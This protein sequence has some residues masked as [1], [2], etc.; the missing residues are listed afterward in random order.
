MG[1]SKSKKTSQPSLDFKI[2]KR[3]LGKKPPPNPN[4]TVTAFKTRRQSIGE[5]DE[6]VM[7]HR[8]LTL[9]DLLGKMKHYSESVR[10]DALNGLRDLI[11]QHPTILN[12][13]LAAIM[14]GIV[15]LANDH[16]KH[17]RAAVHGVLN[18]LFPHLDSVM[19]TPF[20]PLLTIYVSAGMTHLKTSIRMDALSLFELLVARFPV[21]TAAHCHQ[22]IPNY[23][24]LLKRVTVGTTASFQSSTSSAAS[25]SA[26]P[27][28]TLALN[29]RLQILR[30]L[31]K[32]LQLLVHPPDHTFNRLLQDIASIANNTHNWAP[33]ANVQVDNFEAYSNHK[34]IDGLFASNN[35]VASRSSSRLSTAVVSETVKAAPIEDGVALPPTILATSAEVLLLAKALMPILI[36]C[37]LELSP[38]NPI[39]SYSNL[40]DLELLLQ[41]GHL[42]IH[43]IKNDCHTSPDFKHLR[44]DYAKYFTSHFPLQVGSSSQP[45][46]KEWITSSSINSLMT[47]TMAHFMGPSPKTVPEW[48]G[49][50]LDY[51]EDALDGKLIDEG[52]NGQIVKT[53]IS[54][55]LWIVTLL[56]PSMAQEKSQSILTSFIKFDDNCHPHSAA[57]KSCVFFV[58]ELVD[59]QSTIKD[60]SIKKI[61]EWG[62]SSLPKLLWKLGKSDPSTTMDTTKRAQYDFIQ[63]ALVPFFFTISKPNEKFPN[64]R[65][66]YGP[67]T[68]LPLDI[69]IQALN[70]VYYFTTINMTMVRS[71]IAICRAPKTSF[72]IVDIILD[73]TH[74]KYSVTS[75]NNYLAFC[76]AITLSIAQEKEQ[77]LFVDSD[78]VEIVDSG[79]DVDKKR[80]IH[81][82]DADAQVDTEKEKENQKEKEKAKKS[83]L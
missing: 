72:E 10:K 38:S 49:P 69:Q 7:N 17:V 81:D 26:N 80:K 33:V 73:I 18:M 71:L 53:H 42:L 39:I 63:N 60:K 35:V 36:E 29:T 25:S 32:L 55:L 5:R 16:D 50:H 40:E 24:D 51:I 59:I 78:G 9:K 76:I 37:W 65:Q 77:D 11:N 15:E 54:A 28:K 8:H 14:G 61:V 3:R 12:V 67:F 1:R 44:V 57:K 21:L 13:H 56:L 20:I 74:H 19:M 23:M 75:L 34:V 2:A 31:Y 62:L 41:V 83:N 22:M 27:T 4:A 48:F 66:V 46:S 47:Q 68:S 64:G 52:R 58:K 43:S 79:M 30:S 82:V 70:L 6:M 45:D